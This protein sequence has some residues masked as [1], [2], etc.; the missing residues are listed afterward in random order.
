MTRHVV[1]HLPDLMSWLRGGRQTQAN[2]PINALTPHA[3]YLCSDLPNLSRIGILSC[4]ACDQ[5]CTRDLC[6]Q[7]ILKPRSEIKSFC[8]SRESKNMGPIQI[9]IVCGSGKENSSSTVT[10]AHE[11]KVFLRRRLHNKILNKKL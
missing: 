11:D 3:F 6:S 1:P 10:P 5:W 7:R 9:W 2:V 4:V 8:C